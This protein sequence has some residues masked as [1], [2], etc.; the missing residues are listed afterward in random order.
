MERY[1][2]YCQQLNFFTELFHKVK[3]EYKLIHLEKEIF[4][5]I[6]ECETIASCCGQCKNIYCELFFSG[7]VYDE[8]EDYPYTG[9]LSPYH[10]MCKCDL[11]KEEWN[12]FDYKTDLLLDI[13]IERDKNYLFTRFINSNDW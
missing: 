5:D 11:T 4:I 7:H 1:D 3:T 10:I 6:A 2:Y 12:N 9:K 13:T 8:D